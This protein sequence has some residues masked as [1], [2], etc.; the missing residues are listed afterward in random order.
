[1][2]VGERHF[3]GRDQVEVPVAGDLEQILLELRQ[4][5]G[6]AQR[7]GVDEE[8]RL[9]FG[10]AVLARVQLEHEV[11]Q[12]A[13]EPRARA[14][15]HR[16]PRARH[17]AWRARSRGCR[18]RG[19][20]PSAAFGS[21]S[22]VARLAVPADLDVVLGALADRARSRAAGSAASSAARCAAA[23]P[24]SSS[25]SSCL[26]C[27]PRALFAAKIGDGIEPLPLR[28]RDFVAGGV[29]LA[30]QPL[31]LGD[32]APA[33]RLERR[34]AARAPRRARGRGCAARRGRRRGGRGRSRVEHAL[35]PI[36]AHR[37]MVR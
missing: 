28:A 1:M 12:R 36:P 17:A 14:H 18:A 20:D 15:Q 25:I 4:V 32:Q 8:R 11:D 34:R 10:V 30:L 5:A 19:R 26:I 16:E 24:A 21:K 9:D 33:P 37:R 6:A 27:C 13:R 29:L 3:R 31:D 2:Q 35:N 7:V 23:R 22:N